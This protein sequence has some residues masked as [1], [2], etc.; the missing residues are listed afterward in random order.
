MAAKNYALAV[1]VAELR[2]L[3]KGYGDTHARGQANYARILGL[4]ERLA[5]LPAPAATLADLRKAALADE[6]GGKLAERVA[7]VGLESSR[8]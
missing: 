5:A 3:V 4:L 2:N 6:S 1:E 8:P 7:A